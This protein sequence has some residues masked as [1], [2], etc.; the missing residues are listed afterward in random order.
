[1]SRKHRQRDH[2]SGRHRLCVEQLLE[3]LRLLDAGLGV[4]GSPS[5]P[6]VVEFGPV[7]PYPGVVTTWPVDG[8]RIVGSLGTIA[9]TFDQEVGYRYSG[10]DLQLYRIQPESDPIP[11]FGEEQDYPNEPESPI[12]T[13]LELQ[14]QAPLTAGLYELDLIR[15]GLAEADQALAR[16]EVSPGGSTLADADVLSVGPVASEVHGVLDPPGGTNP[17]ALYRIDL[18]GS[19]NLWRLGMQLEPAADGSGALFAVALFDASGTVLKARDAGSGL[20]GAPNSPYLFAGLAP[21]V[22]YVGVSASGNLPGQSG[23]YDPVTGEPGRAGSSTLGGEYRLEVVAEPAA[24]VE[25]TGMSLRW[26]NTYDRSPTGLTLAFSGGID[27]ASL[28]GDGVQTSPLVA[29]DGSGRA[30]GLIA[31]GYDPAAGRISFVFSQRLPSGAYTIE[32]PSSGGLTDL[33]GRAPRADGLPEGVLGRFTVQP[34]ASVPGADDLGVVWP[35]RPEGVGRPVTIAAGGRDSDRVVIPVAGW[36]AL[37]TSVREGR[38]AVDCVGPEG[39]WVVEPGTGDSAGKVTMYLEPGEHFFTFAAS[40]AE[41]VVAA[42]TI[43]AESVLPE[44]LIASGVGQASALQ[45]RLVDPMAPRLTPASPPAL[46]TVVPSTTGTDPVVPTE[47]P[48]WQGPASFPAS[49]PAAEST[50][51]PVPTSL[52]VGVNTAPLGRPSA[53][54]SAA[55]GGTLATPAQGIVFTDPTLRRFGEIAAGR[56]DGAVAP[57]AAPPNS[58]PPDEAVAGNSEAAAAGDALALLRAEELV[59]LANRLGRWLARAVTDGGP[60]PSAPGDAVLAR[61]TEEPGRPRPGGPDLD[62]FGQDR[63]ERATVGV[64]LSLVVAIAAAYRLRHWAGRWWRR[65]PTT[66]RGH[67]TGRESSPSWARPHLGRVRSRPG[68]KGRVVHP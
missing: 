46:V 42:W 16:F 58:D 19:A 57:E 63:V 1:M 25:V 59:A 11:V 68:W 14:F 18:D 8:A 22:Y 40:G 41:A 34:R 6:G 20:A 27:P 44:S 64:P 21:G 35:G 55:P 17:Y 38:L 3:T 13:T 65:V 62:D 60:E 52:L 33:I 9:V 56:G 67:W 32:R 48:T 51:S 24:P 26:D 47:T 12:G 39:W 31:T 37:E 5:G 15:G 7:S 4:I 10:F 29:V 23:G 30:W 43:R 50:A 49:S 66:S 36:Y 61:L 53:E 2:E 28:E 54:A 45:L